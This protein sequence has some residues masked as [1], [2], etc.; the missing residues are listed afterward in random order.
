MIR[1]AVDVVLLPSSRYL[2]RDAT[3]PRPDGP[4]TSCG[5]LSPLE[6]FNAMAETAYQAIRSKRGN[7]AERGD[8]P[9]IM[10]LDGGASLMCAVEVVGEVVRCLTVEVEIALG[11]KR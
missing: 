3:H 4:D 6:G 9:V 7:T 8:L 11:V 5:P 1:Y 2:V 10:K